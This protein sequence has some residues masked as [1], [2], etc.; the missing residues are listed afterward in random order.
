MNPY[1]L[2]ALRVTHIVSAAF[3]VG[4][5][6]TLAFFVFPTL[7]AA[8]MTGVRLM[9]QVMIERKLRVYVILAM[10]M[11]IA[12]GIYLYWRRFSPMGGSPATRAEID[13]GLGAL[14]GILAGI[15]M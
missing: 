10:L 7:M 9:R 3:W 4:A 13:Y 15:V 12:S 11:T 6:S 14:L 1:L 2:Q 5:A 8:E